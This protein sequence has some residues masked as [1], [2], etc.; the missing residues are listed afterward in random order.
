MHRDLVASS[1][2]ASVGYD[3]ASMTLEVEFT[4]GGVYQYCDV[5]DSVYQEF[6]SAPSLGM[7]LNQNIRDNYRYTRL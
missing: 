4:H 3:S 6:M 7:Y 5:P 2:I 1:S